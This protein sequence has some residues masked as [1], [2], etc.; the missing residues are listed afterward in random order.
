MVISFS[1]LDGAGKTTQINN[2]LNA[3]KSQGARVESVYS[4]MPDIRYHSAKELQNLYG[5]LL[6]FD[7]I[8]IRFRLNSDRNHMI[9]Q[10]LESKPPTQLTTAIAAAMQGKFDHL[11][12]AKHL[13]TPLIEKRKILIFD[14]YYYDELVFKRVYGAPNFL[15]KVLYQNEKEADIGFLLKI[16]TDECIK[17]NRFRPD[18]KVPI[19]QSRIHIDSLSNCFDSIAKT[20][21]LIT[22]D[23][24]SPKEIIAKK[25][26][27]QI[28]N[29][30]C[31]RNSSKVNAN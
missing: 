2:L 3:Y 10:E 5:K 28:C 8:H 23:G 13:L 21:N 12:L 27:D 7:V 6:D 4:Y 26:I 16:S 24:E 9:M 18:S 30:Q 22:L 31:R 17:R 29:F 15:L 20:K 11:E 1:G 14:R 19:Y 25:I